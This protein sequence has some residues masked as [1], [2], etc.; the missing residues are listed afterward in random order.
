MTATK[1]IFS[2]WLQEQD[3][4]KTGKWIQLNLIN[5][6]YLLG[7]NHY[8]PL[9][10]MDKSYIWIEET[11]QCIN[12]FSIEHMM[13]PNLR[14]NKSFKEQVKICMKNTF[15]ATTEKHISKILLEPDTRV[16]ELVIFYE[17]RKKFKKCSKC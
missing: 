17:T 14:I 10:H 15:G 3:N 2:S 11:N 7:T 4:L 8:F 9:S 6:Q 1:K 12:D 5:I 16:L 13:N